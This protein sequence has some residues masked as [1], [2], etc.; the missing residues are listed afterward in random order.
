MTKVNEQK[1]YTS[2]ANDNDTMKPPSDKS[3]PS[4]SSATA[5]RAPPEES[6]SDVAVVPEEPNTIKD[7]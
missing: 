5:A 6:P 7:N 3:S 4:S 1:K 2:V